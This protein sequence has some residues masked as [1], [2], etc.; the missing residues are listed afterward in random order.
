NRRLED[1]NERAAFLDGRKPVANIT[2]VHEY[3]FMRDQLSLLEAVLKRP[4]NK[5]DRKAY[6]RLPESQPRSPE[7]RESIVTTP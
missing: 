6:H 4:V 1:Y 2:G 5:V 7:R 3:L